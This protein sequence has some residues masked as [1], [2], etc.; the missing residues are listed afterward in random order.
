MKCKIE[1]SILH[2]FDS[3]ATRG[4]ASTSLP[5]PFHMEKF[6]PKYKNYAVLMAAGL[7]RKQ[8][9]TLVEYGLILALVSIAVIVVLALL[10]N[11]LL[12]IFNT[13]TNTLGTNGS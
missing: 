10:G 5:F 7:K 6:A 9:Q 3:H 13:I 4:L 12:N 11:Q 8:G 2:E 1:L